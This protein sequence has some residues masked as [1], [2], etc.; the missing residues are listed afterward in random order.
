MIKSLNALFDFTARAGLF[1]RAVVYALVAS[2]LLAAIIAPGSGEEGYSPGDTFRRLEAE[3]SGLLVL[4][5]LAAGLWLYALWRGVQAFLD[6]SDEGDDASGYF[7]RLGMLA[8]G[9]SYFTVGIAA[10][11]V[12]MGQNSGSGGGTTESLAELA[13]NQTFGRFILIASGLAVGAIGG[14]Q[15]WRGIS[16]RWKSGLYLPYDSETVCRLITAAIAGRGILIALVG[17]FLIWA[18][19]VGDADEARGIASLLGWLREQPFGLWLYTL[20]AISIASY[21][22]YSLVQ[23]RYLKVDL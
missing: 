11:L 13:L 12:M 15:V 20:S 19:W 6:T 18:G 2:L 16:G 3:E 1:G 7:A 10:A 14:V 9:I 5:M 8:S 17:V 21:G 23:A 4:A 22:F